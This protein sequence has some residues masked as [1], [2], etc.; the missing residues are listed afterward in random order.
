MSLILHRGGVLE[1]AAGPVSNS[2]EEYPHRCWPTLRFRSGPGSS[3]IRATSG[4]AEHDPRTAALPSPAPSSPLDIL[5][6]E[7][8]NTMSARKWDSTAPQNAREM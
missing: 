8:G 1:A 4:H 2:R 7:N 6:I 3:A 5:W